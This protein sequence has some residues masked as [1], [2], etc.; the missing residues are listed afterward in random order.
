MPSK[1]SERP[2]LILQYPTPSDPKHAPRPFH[3][4]RQIYVRGRKGPAPV[5]EWDSSAA[6]VEDNTR[7]EA[8][9][10]RVPQE[11][12]SGKVARGY[13]AGGPQL[14]PRDPSV[15]RLQHE[16]DFDAI[17]IP[18]V[19]HASSG[20]CPDQLAS[21]FSGNESLEQCSRCVAGCTRLH[22]VRRDVVETGG[23][24]VSSS[25]TLGRPI[26]RAHPAHPGPGAPA[27]S[28]HPAAPPAR[29]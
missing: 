28:C 8:R 17:A 13:R 12:Q 4:T 19:E 6:C 2:N 14:H 23:D 24:P 26:T 20:V 29:Q 21:H 15:R 22:R 9:A 3:F 1:A 27:C 11:P 10:E 25:V 16:V 5:S 18:N 7:S